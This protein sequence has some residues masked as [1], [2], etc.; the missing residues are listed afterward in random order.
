MITCFGVEDSSKE[1]I[2]TIKFSQIPKAKKFQWVWVSDHVCLCMCIHKGWDFSQYLCFLTL[3]YC[4]TL[5]G[6]MWYSYT[7]CSDQGVNAERKLVLQNSNDSLITYSQWMKC[8]NHTPYPKDSYTLI[9]P[10]ES[11]MDIIDSSDIT[12]IERKKNSPFW[13]FSLWT[14]QLLLCLLQTKVKCYNIRG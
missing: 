13:G 12:Q 8:S 4:N 6:N 14:V 11:N 2:N 3:W 10:L 9:V 1:H 7:T 5:W